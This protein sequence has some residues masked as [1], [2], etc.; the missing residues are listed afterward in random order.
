MGAPIT[1]NKD[2]AMADLL[3]AAVT[4]AHGADSFMWFLDPTLG[5]ED[6]GEYLK[7]VPG[8]FF[9]LGVDNTAP[10]HHPK[11]NITEAV[12]GKTVAVVDGLMRK[13]AAAR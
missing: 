1:V 12:L 6:F 13:W 9:F 11:F 8:V 3:Q 4:E 10:H 2:Q 7:R 5:G